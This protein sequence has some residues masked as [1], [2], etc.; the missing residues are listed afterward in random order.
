MPRRVLG[1][2]QQEVSVL[3]LGTWPSGKC[4]TVD[5]QAVARI[6]HEALDLGVNYVDAARAYG[7]AEAGIGEALRKNRD[8]V[9]L[10]SKVWAD[11][12]EEARASFEESLRILR[13]DYVDC[14]FIHSG[15][16]RDVERV[17]AP[18]GSL[19]YLL[20]QKEA[21]KTRFLGLSGHSKPMAFIPLLETGNIDL[22]M[23]AMN[24]VDRHTYGFEDKVLPVARKH[25]CGI[26]CMKV[27]GGLKGG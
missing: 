11:T 15:G 23:P 22:L 10:T 2:T 1:R 18:G 17:L 16:N 4:R 3:A 12:A 13:T 8:K 6:V 19:E 7:N 25:H 20:K 24:F 26:A 5:D 9:F 14:L 27:F 21:G